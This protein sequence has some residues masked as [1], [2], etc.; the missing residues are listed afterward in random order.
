MRAALQKPVVLFGCHKQPMIQNSLIQG[1]RRVKRRKSVVSK[2]SNKS[3]VQSL[4]TQQFFI[5]SSYTAAPATTS[6]HSGTSSMNSVCCGHLF[7]LKRHLDFLNHSN[8]RGEF[9]QCSLPLQLANSPA[10]PMIP[11]QAGR[12]AHTAYH[13][14]CS[15]G[16]LIT[17]WHCINDGPVTPCIVALF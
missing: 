8:H 17:A 1:K 5:Y 9:W 4:S 13:S 16:A 11:S 2:P 10:L 15:D 6:K 3:L 14:F 12:A 7:K